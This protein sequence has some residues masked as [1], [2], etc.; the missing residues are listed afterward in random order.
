VCWLVLFY[1]FIFIINLTQIIE[2][3]GK[4]NQPR[5]DLPKGMSLEHFIDC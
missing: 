4:G 5:S 1:Y 2:Q 3:E